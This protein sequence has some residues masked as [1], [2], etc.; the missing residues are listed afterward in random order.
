MRTH[1][2]TGVGGQGPRAASL[3]DETFPEGIGRPKAFAVEPIPRT[4]SR[5]DQRRSGFSGFPKFRQFVNAWAR[6]PTA[7]R[8]RHT[9]SH[10][11]APPANRSIDERCDVEPAAMTRALHE[12]VKCLM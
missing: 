12:S 9:S 11:V 10:A 8:L 5:N 1:M 3:E 4:A 6:A 2:T 7:A